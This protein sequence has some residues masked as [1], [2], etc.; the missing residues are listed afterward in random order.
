LAQSDWIFGMDAPAAGT[1]ALLP[2]LV[3]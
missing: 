1:I 3:G 2:N